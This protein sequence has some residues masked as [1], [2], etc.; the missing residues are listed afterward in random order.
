ML[1]LAALAATAAVLAATVHYDHR[2]HPQESPVV[3]ATVVTFLVLTVLSTVSRG[4]RDTPAGRAAAERWLGLRDFL[5]GDE[6]FAQLPPAAS[7]SGTATCP[8]A[9]RWA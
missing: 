8:T 4:E 2:T 7:S 5:R 9:A 1:A 3:G 6:A